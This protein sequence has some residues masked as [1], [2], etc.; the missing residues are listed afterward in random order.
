[1]E[2]EINDIVVEQMTETITESRYN[3][4]PNKKRNFSSRVQFFAK[5]N[6]KH[7]VRAMMHEI[8]KQRVNVMFTQMQARTGIKK[9]GQSAISVMFK[10]YV[11]LR[12]L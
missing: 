2:N 5:Q 3:L 1:M 4:R 12:D 7:G 11:Q 6:K 9:H 10:E 8:H